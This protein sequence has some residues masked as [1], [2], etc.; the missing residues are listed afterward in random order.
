MG[1]RQRRL[2]GH[3]AVSDRYA[4]AAQNAGHSP[5]T[6]PAAGLQALCYSGTWA[7]WMRTRDGDYR[8]TPNDLDKAIYEIA[9]SPIAGSDVG[10]SNSAPILDRVQACGFGVTH[11]IPDC[12][13]KYAD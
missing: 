3:H 7:S 6:G 8:L 13:D 9:S 11:Q 12:F 4:L 5:I 1:F 2:L 10:G